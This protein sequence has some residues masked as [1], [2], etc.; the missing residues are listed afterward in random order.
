[1][2]MSSEKL[3]LPNHTQEEQDIFQKAFTKDFENLK[4]N[5]VI[6]PSFCN[7]YVTTCNMSSLSLYTD[8]EAQNI[9]QLSDPPGKQ[10]ALLKSV[11]DKGPQ[12]VAIF[13]LLL[14]MNDE[15]AYGELPSCKEN[16]FAKPAAQVAPMRPLIQKKEEKNASPNTNEK[17]DLEEKDIN[18]DTSA[19]EKVG[20][21]DKNQGKSQRRSWGIKKDDE[22]FHFIIVC[23]ALG[24]VLVCEYY[25]SDWTV[26]AGFGL[27]SFATLETIGIYFGLV[28]RIRTVVEQFLPLVGRFT[29]GSKK[30]G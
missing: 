12:A 20:K 5:P 29:L 30:T 17:K 18:E 19:S 15:R 6:N 28:Y 16:G 9:I 13:Y 8:K 25:Y 21:F 10:L 22:F 26:S 7:F 11:D 3:S 23:F 1:M 27:L 2:T 24:A 14:Q 4:T